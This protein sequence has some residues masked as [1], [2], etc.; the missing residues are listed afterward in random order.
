MTSDPFAEADLFDAEY[1]RHEARLRSNATTKTTRRAMTPLK[2]SDAVDRAALGMTAQRRREIQAE[3][4]TE[5]A[6]EQAAAERKRAERRPPHRDQEAAG[7]FERGRTA[8]AIMREELIYRPGS[9]HSYLRDISAGTGDQAAMARLHGNNTQYGEMIQMRAGVTQ[10]AGSGGEFV[11]PVW[12]MQKY[13]PALRSGRPFLN[14]LGTNTVKFKGNQLDFP[15]FTSGASVA[16]QTDGNAPSNTD[17]VTAKLTA[18][19]QTE[20]GRSVASWQ[21]IDLN[22]MSEEI[23]TRDLLFAYHSQ[24]DKDILAASSVANAK[25]VI[26]TVGVNTVSY[27]DAS[28]TSSEY[29]APISQAAA[30][31]GKVGLIPDFCVAHPSVGYLIL[32]GLDSQT[33]P[34]FSGLGS[35]SSMIGST[36]TDTLALAGGPANYVANVAGIPM[37][38]D[39]NIP[40]TLGAGAESRLVVMNRMGYDVFESTVG[41]KLAD[42][43]GAST[44]Q[45]QLVAWGYWAGVSRQ[46]KAISVISG[47]GLTVQAGY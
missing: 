31:I 42:Q 13:A 36:D 17:P 47:T 1:Q 30:A 34:I 10:T 8:I 7:A 11:P 14:G 19:V 41:I 25:S 9:A 20:A 44:L 39:P 23:L 37:L 3:Y 18:Q 4:E 32:G 21:L 15:S 38:L 46:P 35:G 45:S 2:G 6:A 16:V 28:P 33:R 43:T 40:T 12:L 29:W 5:V 26:N 27:T 22:P 24:L